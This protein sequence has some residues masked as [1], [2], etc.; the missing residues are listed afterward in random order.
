MCCCCSQI[1]VWY[2]CFF[3]FIFE[4]HRLWDKCDKKPGRYLIKMAQ[5]EKSLV[6]EFF[7]NNEVKRVKGLK[8]EEDCLVYKHENMR[9][10]SFTDFAEFREAKGTVLEK[11]VHG[12]RFT[13]TGTYIKSL[14]IAYLH[15]IIKAVV[16]D[17]LSVNLFT[18]F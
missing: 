8:Y 12:S 18:L 14:L 1:Y 4:T 17:S 5:S 7:R 2:R 9:A 3:G 6:V 15:S 13:Y 16:F 10:Q 11:A